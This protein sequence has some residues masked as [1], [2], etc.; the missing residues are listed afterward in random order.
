MATLIR[1]SRPH[2]HTGQMQKK[3]TTMMK[4]K[5]TMVKDIGTLSSIVSVHPASRPFSAEEAM[6]DSSKPKY[7]QHVLS[8]AF[9]VKDINDNPAILPNV[10]L[11]FQIY[12][13]E[14]ISEIITYQN[15]LN[16]LSTEKRMVPNF[17]CDQQNHLISV[18]GGLDSEVSCN[19]ATV[20]GIYKIPQW[21]PQSEGKSHTAVCERVDPILMPYEYY[22]AEEII[23]GAI[24]THFACLFDEISYTENPNTMVVNELLSKP[25]CYQHVLSLVFAVKEINGNPEILP[26]V[27]LGF[28]IYDSYAN[29]IITYQNTLNLLSTEKRMVPNF[30]CN[31]QNHLLSVIGGLDS[32]V[33]CNMAT[34]LGIY[35]I[36]QISS[37]VL[38]PVTNAKSQFPSFYR[39][40]PNEEH[41]YRG[42][43]HLVLHF[44]WTWVGLITADDENG[45]KF[46]Q[47]LMPMLTQNGI[48]SALNEKIPAA[49]RATDA[50]ASLERLQIKSISILSSDVKVFIVNTSHVTTIY[51][52]WLIYF[53]SL[54]EDIA[55][56]S[57]AKVWLLTAQWNFAA[58]ILQRAYDIQI[59]DGALSFA[60]HSNEVPGFTQFLQSLRPDSPEGDGFLRIFWEH[61]FNCSFSDSSEGKESTGTCTGQEK[62]ESLPGTLFEMSM[63]SQ[64]YSI[65]NAIYAIAHALHEIY[66][67]RS[68]ISVT[69]RGRENYLNV[70]PWQ[71]HSF[72]RSISFN[73]NAGDTI[74]FDENDEL[75]AGFDIINWVTFPNQTFHKVKVGWMDP[76]SLLGKEFAIKGAAITWHS[77]FKQGMPLAVCNDHCYPG[78]SRKTKEGQPFCCYDCVPCA[79]GKISTQKALV[80]G[81]F[82]KNQ[83]TPIVK[84]NNR[85]LTYSLLISLL[86]CFL[87]SLL[88]I[89]RPQRVTCY[90][91]QTSFGTIF[92]VAVSCVLAKT[93]TV[94]L[95][96]LATKP[97]SKMRK[98]V[99]K[100]L[101]NSVVLCCCLI[102]VTIC[103]LWLC[104]SPPSPNLDMHLL[105]EEI[106]VECNEGS[107]IMFYCVLGYLGILA[108][109]SFTVAFLARKLPDSF[110]EAKFITFSML[111]FCSVWLTF[112]P[113]YLSA[114]GKS[115]VAVEI[116]SILASG[117]GLLVF[118][119]FPKCYII[120]LKPELNCKEQLR[121]SLSVSD[122]RVTRPG[123]PP[124]GMR[125]EVAYHHSTQASLW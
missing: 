30:K 53:Y 92:S 112:V 94:V 64:S 44:H 11:G 12:D 122:S 23:I 81:I 2:Y 51:L 35:K 107:L 1:N 27:S 59:F 77:K 63:M 66:T 82:I 16:L 31:K 83:N 118:I 90:L 7:Y 18:I 20:L 86:L 117:A 40:V 111:I 43:V 17:K 15:T 9:A 85:D 25:K 26:N 113:S 88:F 70:Q 109:V 46:V 102:Q 58:E 45:E 72:L 37:S 3:T 19:M 52:K 65:Y 55:M 97:G 61:A 41:Q 87:C 105:A 6:E 124:P 28:Q 75:A 67:S 36:P 47:T 62:V 104:M 69:H 29:E 14:I 89:G 123:Q 54:F 96:F 115:V 13:S 49:S 73:N 103:A 80:L 116:F 114:K 48:C 71:L 110:N 22:K 121:N 24:V 98:W 95:A 4:K 32:E 119:F 79:E 76:Q 108:L 50:L 99:G 33:S 125:L 106:I 100:R 38:A 74:S 60:I 34:V 57:L 21:L 56:S 39:M 120:I 101:A 78:Y 93:I 8:L 42:M 84:A 5:N 91:R 10:S 68:K